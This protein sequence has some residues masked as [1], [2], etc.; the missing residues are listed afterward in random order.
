MNL[1]ISE[2]KE[3]SL[4]QRTEV[5]G[6]ITFDG[7]TPSAHDVTE[8]LAKSFTDDVLLVVV[9][10]IHT[11]FGQQKA[12]VTAVVYDSADARKRGEVMTKHLRKKAEE[13]AK[14]RAE[15][16]KKTAGEAKKTEQA[17]PE[18]PGEA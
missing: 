11:I 18:S 9:K 4:L 13:E 15:E 6:I 5:K 17:T 3:N 2:Q 10:K 1:A 7:A 14:K 8:A 12:A 16:A